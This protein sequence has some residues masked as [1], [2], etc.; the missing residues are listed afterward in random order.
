MGLLFKL[1]KFLYTIFIT[2]QLTYLGYAETVRMKKMIQ[3][4]QNN[5]KKIR[6]LDCRDGV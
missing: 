4:I 6:V 2:V 3:F 5:A 1:M